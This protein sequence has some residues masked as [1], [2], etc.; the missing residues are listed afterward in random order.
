MTGGTNFYK[1]IPIERFDG[2]IED[3][4]FMSEE[5]AVNYTL[6]IFLN[7]VRRVNIEVLGYDPIADIPDELFKRDMTETEF[8]KAIRR[9][10]VL[11]RKV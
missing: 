6:D 7:G 5:A 3:L 10:R 2:N 4:N 8:V 9:Y 1:D 11:T